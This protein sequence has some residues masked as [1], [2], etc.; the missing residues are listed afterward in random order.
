M[1]DAKPWYQSKTI[2]GGLIAILAAVMQA[3]GKE[4]SPASAGD[5]TEAATNVAGAVGGILAVYGRLSA[6]TNITPN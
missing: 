1:D 5:L 4:I 2:W 3:S 6:R